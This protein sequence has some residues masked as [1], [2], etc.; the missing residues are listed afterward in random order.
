MSSFSAKY[1]YNK[2]TPYLSVDPEDSSNKKYVLSTDI[3]RADVTVFDVN[4]VTNTATFW[5]PTEIC[6]ATKI[7]SSD[8]ESGEV[9]CEYASLSGWYSCSLSR[10]VPNV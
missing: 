7:L 10:I 2:Q 3:E 1:L 8:A 9:S 6:S 4:S 5:I